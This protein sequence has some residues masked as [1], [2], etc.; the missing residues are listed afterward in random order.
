MRQSLLGLVLLVTCPA[1]ILAGSYQD[2][3]NQFFEQASSKP[4]RYSESD[5][6]AMKQ[7]GEELARQMPNPGIKIGEKAPDFSLT[8]A[9][10]KTVTLSEELK[11][12]PVVLVFYRGAWCPFCNLHLHALNKRLPDIA[13]YGAQ[14]ITV[15]PQQPDKSAEQIKKDSYPFEVLSDLD[16]GVMKTYRLY[17]ELPDQLITVYKQHGLDVEAFNGKGRNVLPIPGSFVIDTDGVVRA[18]HAETD[19]KQRMEPDDMI[20]ALQEITGKK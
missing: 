16:S 1:T 11:K 10:G 19:Y 15:T 17:Y 5:M 18:M 20:K 7:A 12:G 4:S 8:N 2:A 13:R 9:F 14:L 6:A 3:L